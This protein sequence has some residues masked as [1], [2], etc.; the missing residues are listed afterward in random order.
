LLRAFIAFTYDASRRP[1]AHRRKGYSPECVEGVF[2]EVR[3]AG[4]PRLGRLA[5]CLVLGRFE[6]RFP[7]RARREDDTM[8]QVGE[9]YASGRWLVNEG[10]EDEFVE[11]WTTFT[12]W[13]LDNVPGARSYVLLR[14]KAEARRFVSFGAFESEEA[15]TQ[16][17]ERPEFAELR[18][19]CI[20]LCEE[21]EPHDYT[22]A[23]SPS[24]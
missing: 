22:V 17:R 12:Q 24:R 7:V 10:S 18:D 1:L 23:A 15:V 9:P 5:T 3:R 21:F 2:C 6:A 4:C 11:R 13:S 16:W 14:D 8:A 19:A 20:H